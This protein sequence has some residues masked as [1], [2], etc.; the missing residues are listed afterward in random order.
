MYLAKVKIG[1]TWER[2]TFLNLDEVMKYGTE[3]QLNPYLE[4]YFYADSLLSTE[5]NE[6]SL[7]GV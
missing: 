3:I 6:V 2:V 4:S 5:Y 7:G 1:N